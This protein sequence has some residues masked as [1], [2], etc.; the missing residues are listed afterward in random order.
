VGHP[1]ATIGDWRFE[2]VQGKGDFNCVGRTDRECLNRSAADRA[3]GAMYAAAPYRNLPRELYGQRI[4]V[5]FNA[6]EACDR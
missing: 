5:T 2:S 6:R 1:V 4:S 3:F